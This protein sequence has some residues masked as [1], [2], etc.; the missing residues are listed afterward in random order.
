[1]WL[2]R[3]SNS[4]PLALEVDALPTALRGQAPIS[5]TISVAASLKILL[6]S[7][8]SGRL[9]PLFPGTLFRCYMSDETICHFRVVGPIL[10]LL[11]YIFYG[12]S[13]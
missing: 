7:P 12:K 10:L 1:M 2:D 13:C 3:I 11:F 9:N 5:Y 6:Y 4:G 8:G